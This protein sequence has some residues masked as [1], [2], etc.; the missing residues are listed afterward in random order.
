MLSVIQLKQPRFTMVATASAVVLLCASL[1]GVSVLAADSPARQLHQLNENSVATVE[2]PLLAGWYEGQLVHYISTDMSDQ[3]MSQQTGTN[4]VSRLSYALRAPLPGQPTAVDRVFKFTNFNQGSVFP[5]APQ[6]IGYQNTS[7]A[8][9]PLWVVYL[10]TWQA[11]TS[12]RTLR[13]EEEVL[14]AADKHE[15]QL[16]P[17]TVVVNCPIIYSAKDGLLGGATIHVKQQKTNERR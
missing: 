3:A 7:E 2:L 4:Y 6:K 14:S 15:I 9:T 17:T 12:P 5:S 1:C 10:V 11:G 13:S 16:T 8:Y